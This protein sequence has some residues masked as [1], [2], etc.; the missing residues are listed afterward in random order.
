MSVHWPIIRRCLSEYDRVAIR[1][2]RG[3]TAAWKVVAGALHIRSAVRRVCNS[4]TVGLLIPT[5]GAFPVAALGAW[6]AGKVIVPLNY[7]LKQEDLQ[8]VVD[9]CET[10]TIIASG[11]LLEHLGYR[12]RV[13]NLLILEEMNFKR[14]PAPAIPARTKDDSLACLLY[15]SGTSGRPKGV[16]LTHAN[17]KANVGQCVEWVGF[18][19]SQHSMLGVLPQ[20]HTFGLTVLTLLPLMTGLPVTYTARFMPTRILALMRE[21]RPTVFVAIPSMYGALLNL[22]SAKPEDFASLQIAVS[23]G[24]PLPRSIFEGFRDRYNITINE[25]YGLTETAPVINWCRPGEWRSGSVGMPLPRVRERICDINTGQEVPQGEEGEIRVK[26]PN[27]M[28]GYFKRQEDT[29]AAFDEDHWFRTG[30]IGRFDEAGHLHI[31]GRLKEMLIV[32]GENVFPRE[33]E[34][35]LNQHASVNASGVVGL[36]D[37]IRGEVPVAFVE[38]IEGAEFS[39]ESLRTHCRQH[40]TGY[41]VPRDIRVLDALP[42]NPTGKIMRKELKKMLAE[43]ARA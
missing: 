37:D 11:A 5:S 20:F 6:M 23:G 19:G 29:A 2:D 41:K 38:L 16:M 27:V 42:R 4:K 30:D 22:K 12:P 21:Q 28:Q 25:G 33:I 34:E 24:E 36:Q 32:G 1:D 8:F 18:E 31:T 9:D 43:S 17:L 40:L 39:E 3:E 13:K 7:L 26:G 14:L 35:V 10:D 15:T